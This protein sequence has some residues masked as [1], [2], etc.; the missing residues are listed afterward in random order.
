MVSRFV[1]DE[2][3]IASASSYRRFVLSIS[4]ISK[5]E[6]QFQGYIYCLVCELTNITF[7]C[8]GNGNAHN[9]FTKTGTEMQPCNLKPFVVC[10]CVGQHTFSR[11]PSLNFRQRHMNTHSPVLMLHAIKRSSACSL[12]LLLHVHLMLFLSDRRGK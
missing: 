10:I 8:M 2:V 12:H 3:K 9:S 5:E 1:Y 6:K 4:L 11:T 7:I